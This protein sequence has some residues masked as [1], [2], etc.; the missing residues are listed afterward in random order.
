MSTHVADSPLALALRTV[1]VNGAYNASRAL[2]KWLR[3]G[4]RLHTDGFEEVSIGDASSI[5][6][7]PETA[8][9]GIHLPL[10]GDVTGHML[11]AFPEDVALSL[12]D[13]LTQQSLGTSAE[14]DELAQS[15][16]QETGNIVCS[17]YGNS[18]AHWLKLHIEPNVPA[19]V[20]DMASSIVDPLLMESAVLHDSVLVARTD[21]LLDDKSLQWALLL[22]PSA[23]SLQA[24]EQRCQVDQAQQYALKTIAVNGAY[25]ASRAVSKWLKR[26]VKISTEGFT[27]IPLGEMSTL[28]PTESKVVALQVSIPDPLRGHALFAA[29]SE[30]ASRLANLLLGRPA[31]DLTPL[32]ELE[33]SSLEETGNIIVSSFLNSWSAWLDIRLEPSA[34]HMVE[35]APEAVIQSILSDQAAVSDEV[36]LART[37]FVMDDQWLKWVFLIL[38]A[39]SAMRLIEAMRQ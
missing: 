12:V 34:P 36:F 33:R 24:M 20:H 23:T 14:F 17:A 6:G 16:L 10:K 32:G 25:N 4:V 30:D 37:D 38:P 18:L 28:F 35:D 21:F 19:F 13:V 1:A 27:T 2:S 8:I 22:L 3:R 9:A 31:H 29:T 5:L 7:D 39:P 11:L 26:G 15:C